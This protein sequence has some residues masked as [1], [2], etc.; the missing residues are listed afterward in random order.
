MPAIKPSQVVGNIADEG[1]RLK[2]ERSLTGREQAPSSRGQAQ[3]WVSW[4]DLGRRLGQPFDAEQIPYSKLRQMRR[5]PMVAFGLHYIKT[6]LVRAQWRIECEDAQV[7][8]FVD[9]A[10]RQIHAR[11]MFARSLA[12]DFGNIPIA[13]RFQYEFPMATYRDPESPDTPK[14]VWSE[15]AV[16]ALTWK[17]FVPLPPDQAEP[18]WD[19]ATGE[20]A[21]IKYQS[22]DAQGGGGGGGGSDAPDIDIYHT[23]WATNEKDSVM[24]SLYGYPRIAYAYRYW[25][26]YWFRWA[27]YDRFFERAAVPPLKVWHP[28]GRYEDPVTGDTLEFSEVAYEAGSRLRANGIVTMPSDLAESRSINGSASGQ[29]AWEAEYMEPGKPPIDFDKSFDYLDVMKLRS[30]FVPEQ[31]FVEGE[32][33]SSSRNVASQ[34]AEIFV[35]SQAALMAEADDEINRY[36]IPQLVA[37]N[38]PEFTGVARKVTQGFSQEDVDF[39]KQ[40]IQLIGQQDPFALGVD[41]RTALGNLGMPLLTPAE[42]KRQQ[43]EL[44]AAKT[45]PVEAT[46]RP[47]AAGVQNVQG[48]ATGYEYVQHPEVIH[49][50]DTDDFIAS[51]PASAHFAD[52]ETRK[53]AARLHR[54][55]KKEF[56]DRVKDLAS[57]IEAGDISIQLSGDDFGDADAEALGY[58]VAAEDE[59]GVSPSTKVAATVVTAA[60]AKK[61]ANQ[62]VD[63]WTWPQQQLSYLAGATANALTRVFSKAITSLADQ[64]GLTKRPDSNAVKEWTFDRGRE[65][66]EQTDKSLRQE[67]AVFIREALVDGHTDP[68]DLAREMRSHFSDRPAS[69]S[70]TVAVTET[71]GAWNRATL[72]LAQANDVK[73]VQA[74]DAQKGPTDDHCEKRDGR[75]FTVKGALKE[76]K[77]RRHPNCTLE[78]RMLQ[79]D[80]QLSLQFTDR[81]ES[82][83]LATY[84]PESSTVWF[85]DESSPPERRRY[86]DSLIMTLEPRA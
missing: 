79:P 24:G 29:R 28:D 34:M 27:M 70:E 77:D 65:V 84:D 48:S 67:M 20:L 57:K 39:L 18:V 21:G 4:K 26:S 25:W 5:D 85:S 13:K 2:I 51:L 11:Y 59:E 1:E 63:K 47:N 23:L 53:V 14:P 56:R 64:T 46:P 62:I 38:F 68:K 86:L 73:Q 33:G 60:A 9:Y 83:Q 40:I 8:A 78:W 12:L 36:I 35:Q 58:L 50:S 74:R 66:V 69:K 72:E 45:A 32:G 3:S 30:L 16:P 54:L 31:A 44:I 15:G 43:E 6:P 10:W 41:I 75:L 7:A 37:V 52:E 22:P 42:Q 19:A 61:I 17:P 76:D 82:H 80:V 81:M 55:Y 49:L 71:V